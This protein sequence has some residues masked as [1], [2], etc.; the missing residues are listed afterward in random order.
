MILANCLASVARTGGGRNG[1]DRVVCVCGGF[2]RG[3]GPR[4]AAVN[5]EEGNARRGSYRNTSRSAR[6]ATRSDVEKPSVN[7]A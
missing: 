6:A 1:S 7:R 4:L 3:T 2:P 5:A